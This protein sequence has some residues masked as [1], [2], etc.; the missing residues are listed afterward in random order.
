MALTRV[1][2]RRR[3]FTLIE[4]LV[5]IAIIGILISLLLPAVQKIREAAARMQCSNNFKQIGLATHNYH[6]AN[7]VVPPFSQW[8]WSGSSL[9]LPPVPRQTCTNCRETGMFY[10]LLAYVEQQNL[11]NLNRTQRNQGYYFPGAG[12]TDYCVDVGQDIVKV[13][14]CPAD[15]TNPTHIDPTSTNNNGPLYATASYAA[16]ALV[17]DP[18]P[19]PRAILQ[20]MP[21]GTSNTVIFGHRLEYCNFGSPDYGYNDWDATPDQTGT[22]VPLPGF[23]W[24]GTAAAPGYVQLRC[25]VA[26]NCYFGPRNQAGGGLN[27]LKSNQWPNFADG[28]L[29]FQVQPRSGQCDPN[30]LASPHSV[31]L[32]GLGDGS[33]RAVQPG[34]SVATWLAVCIPDSGAVVGSDW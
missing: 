33:V 14:L 3:G 18:N 15:G 12:W 13:Y 9:Y 17:F 10:S 5:V 24:S 19:A 11:A 27:R 8:I 20:A 22:W 28:S 2:R 1:F 26:A 34:I 31:M 4:L 7:N 21:N 29:P 30:V 32:V 25:S 16:N 6:D 23:G